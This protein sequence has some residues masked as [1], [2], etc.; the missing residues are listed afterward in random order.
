[1]Y[2]PSVL[3]VDDYISHDVATSEEGLVF[4]CLFV[5][6]K[7]HM[8]TSV[9]LKHVKEQIADKIGDFAFARHPDEAFKMMC[10]K[11]YDVVCLDGGFDWIWEAAAGS[12]E[13]QKPGCILPI[14]NCSS[15]N[16]TTTAFMQKFE[17]PD[18]ELLSGLYGFNFN[19]Y[20]D[21]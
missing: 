14:S 1:V 4:L 19:H 18:F 9:S 12:T 2:K 16:R 10:E 5:I 11:K 21:D 6:R 15:R 13:F 3:F 17:I 7:L 20:Y 8:M